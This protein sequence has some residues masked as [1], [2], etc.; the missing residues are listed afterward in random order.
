MQQLLTN[1]N[2][3][4]DNV[5]RNDIL[6]DMTVKQLV[7]YYYRSTERPKD[8]AAV[9]TLLISKG[10]EYQILKELLAY[11]EQGVVSS[12]LKRMDD[13][14]LYQKVYGMY[15]IEEFYNLL[16]IQRLYTE[17]K[18]RAELQVYLERKLLAGQLTGSIRTLL[19]YLIRQSYAIDKGELLVTQEL[20]DR[21]LDTEDPIVN[22]KYPKGKVQNVSSD[23]LGY[24]W[25]VQTDYSGDEFDSA[26]VKDLP[27]YN[28]LL[29]NE[30]TGWT[31][32]SLNVD[33]LKVGYYRQF[34]EEIAGTFLGIYM[35]HM[36]Y[37]MET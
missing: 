19:R 28:L 27:F 26:L 32:Q 2:S 15:G 6:K 7:I 16:P 5:G 14:D 31:L 25:K 9:I 8:K 33:N 35:R 20:F 37:Y 10:V 11:S 34:K 17:V 21:I 3:P 30:Q 23:L 24:L 4:K 22:G 12:L 1:S 29:N 13:E 18:P 36:E